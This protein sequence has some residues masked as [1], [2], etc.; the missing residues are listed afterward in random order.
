MPRA[1]SHTVSH[2]GA[3]ST[4]DNLPSTATWKIA[5]PSWI[6]GTVA[7][8]HHCSATNCVR[9]VRNARP[10]LVGVHTR[11]ELCQNGKAR[12]SHSP[13]QLPVPLSGRL[14]PQESKARYTPS[15]LWRAPRQPTLPSHP[16]SQGLANHLIFKMS[17]SWCTLH[18]LRAVFCLGAHHC[19]REM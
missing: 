5:Q 19:G 7:N 3:L 1:E 2:T 16:Y 14:G 8:K 15:T 18:Q 17:S 10:R 11:S 13:C 4:L 6:F 9:P 12:S